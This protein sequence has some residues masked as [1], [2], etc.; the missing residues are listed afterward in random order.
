MSFVAG[1][2]TGNMILNTSGFTGG[3][4]GMISAATAGGPG[5]AAPLL[6]AANLVHET[7][8]KLFDF[9]KES[10]VGSAEKWDNMGEA[11]E[12]AGVSTEFLSSMGLMAKDAGSSV[13]G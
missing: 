11:A 5:M 9:I 2:I 4:A 12:K 13:E 1:A 7:F 3:I 8:A 6:A 10:I